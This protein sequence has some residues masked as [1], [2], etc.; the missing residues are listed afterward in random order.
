MERDET[1][2]D[3]YSDYYGSIRSVQISYESNGAK[4]NGAKSDEPQLADTG[5]GISV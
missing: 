3:D 5:S 1:Q 4:S 2:A